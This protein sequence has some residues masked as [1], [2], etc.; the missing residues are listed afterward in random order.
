LNADGQ[1]PSPAPEWRV[2]RFG[3]IDSTSEEARRR[4]LNGDPGRLWIVAA[5]QSA[6]RGRRGRTWVSPA[7]NLYASALLIDPCAQARATQLGFVAGAALARSARDLGA[8]ARL[9]WPNDLILGG[10][11]CA[12]LLVEGLQ[13][14]DQ[15]FACIVGI[16]VN[17][18]S[19][20]EAV[21]YPTAV[22]SGRAG[23]P[24][25]AAALF[26]RLEARFAEALQEWRGGESFPA[27]R[28]SWLAHAGPIGER[29][30]ISGPGGRRDG[31]FEGLDADGR[32]L[33]RGE[34]G[35]ETVETADLWILP[36]MDDSPATDA[37]ALAG[38][39]R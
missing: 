19:A 25:Q 5:E 24:I 17:C 28:E 13:L 26:A 33:F 21:G 39:G 22:L 8:A 18:A 30:R 23:A 29:I 4:A 36:E 10:A 32:L 3:T 1:R 12:G 38:E 35:I 27:I 14:P 31:V 15:R 9:K 34:Q 2:A 20:P 7:G 11:K 16:G 6:G 37:S